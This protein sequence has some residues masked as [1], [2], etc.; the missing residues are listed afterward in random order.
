MSR[1]RAGQI[2]LIASVILALSA[3]GGRTR[4]RE[5][6]AALY[7]EGMT[8]YGQ[9]QLLPACERWERALAI[10]RK[11]G[12]E[13]QAAATLKLLGSA[14]L[15]AGDEDRGRTYLEQELELYKKPGM[16]RE[17]ADAAYLLGLLALKRDDY[18]R[19]LGYLDQAQATYRA[20]GPPEK[21]AETEAAMRNLSHAVGADSGAPAASQ[22]DE[23]QRANAV[24]KEGMRLS[25]QR[26][27][28][29]ARERWEQALP[30]YRRLKLVEEE[31]GVLT[32][33]GTQAGAIG[34]PA[35]ADAYLKRAL[36]CYRKLDSKDDVADVLYDIAAVAMSA[37][38]SDQARRYFDQA[39][40][41]YAARGNEKGI[42]KTRDAK[43]R[44]ER[45][46]R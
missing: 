45:L 18:V 37:G 41:A 33:L 12:L 43:Q 26:N 35:E 27:Y 15:Q 29:G 5:R 7:D 36:V 13:K 28:S 34:Q 40:A 9:K 6:A 11:Q 39:L 38:K 30:V 25:D 22:E 24:V 32:L 8:L 44:L 31:A 17:A 16:E 46:P 23:R 19:A 14:T 42:A 3:C 2:L 20:V 1:T 10:Y 21:L 4:E